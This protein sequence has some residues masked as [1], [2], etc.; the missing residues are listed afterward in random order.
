MIAIILAAAQ[1]SRMQG[2]DEHL[3][4]PL[5]PLGDRPFLFHVIEYL[6]L[7]GV[8]RFEFLL[9][10]LPEK[11]ENY[12]G[13]G[14]RWGCSFQFHLLSAQARPYRMAETIATALDDDT[15]IGRGDNLPE[16]HLDG[17]TGPT[18][19]TAASGSWTGWAFFPRAPSQ[20]AIL[21]RSFGSRVLVDRFGFAQVRVAREISFES[22]SEVLRSQHALLSGAVPDLMISGRQT[23][24][25]IWISRNVSLHPSVTLTAPV[26]IGP[27]CRIGRGAR[28][29]P[30]AVISENCI[31]DEHSSVVDSIVTAG[32]Y[33]GQGLELDHVIVDR[34]LLFNVR[35]ETAF[36]VSES[37]M[38]SGLRADG[39]S[40]LL[41]QFFSRAAALA[42]AFLFYPFAGF[43]FLVFIVTGKGE[44]TKASR[45]RIPADG[46]PDAWQEYA[47]PSFC[48]RTDGLR[49]GA[50]PGRW[51]SFFLNFLPGLLAVLRG[52]L[53]LVGVQPRPRRAIEELP[54]DWRSIYLKSKG[55]L[56]TEAS[57]MFGETPTEDEVYTAEA[58]Y[59]ATESAGHDL[60]LIWLYF[61]RLVS[62]MRT[63]GRNAVPEAHL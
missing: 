26:Y 58:F 23:E 22:G 2:L 7:Q 46:H 55:G 54:G 31:V 5:F 15:L 45:V 32:T 27:N 16:I 11:I 53:F 19:F 51:A 8:R 52:D 17:L 60:K 50:A 3:P 6:A 1:N 61:W 4:L 37:F 62:S 28:I 42:L 40:G 21:D 25:G 63:D 47:L 33:I 39:Q 49:A 13:D 10:H 29:G 14:A 34:N 30:S 41:R 43:V 35:L 48:L 38:L 44:L 12:L 59:S 24:P 20:I 57:V 56:I 9:S 36:L 18:L